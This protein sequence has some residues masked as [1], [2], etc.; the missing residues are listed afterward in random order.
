MRKGRTHS[1][2]A[3]GKKA[4]GKRSGRKRDARASLVALGALAAGI[5]AATYG[6]THQRTPEIS[7]N[8]APG[9]AAPKDKEI[10]AAA[11]DDS[12]GKEQ[13]AKKEDRLITGSLPAK[14]EEIALPKADTQTKPQAAKQKNPGTTTAKIGASKP[15]FDFFDNTLQQKR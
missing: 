3:L 1:A 14:Q 4:A 9:I 6:L 2:R 7:A 10:A 11:A 5:L 15:F 12:T 13:T 8:T